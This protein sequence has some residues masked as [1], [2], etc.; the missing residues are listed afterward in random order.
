MAWEKKWLYWTKNFKVSINYKILKIIKK[1][2]RKR[3]N[4]LIL[5]HILFLL[6]LSLE[7]G[8]ELRVESFIKNYQ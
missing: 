8:F 7:N 2:Q 1:W 3:I 6:I 5:Q 4:P